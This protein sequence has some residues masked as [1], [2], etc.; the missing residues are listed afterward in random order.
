MCCLVR[1]AL[2]AGSSRRSI[3]VPTRMMGVPE[4]WCVISG[5]HYLW[6]DILVLLT[7]GNRRCISYLGSNVVVGWRAHNGEA[8]EK[9]IS[10]RI[11][12]GSESII[13]LLTC[14][15]PKTQTDWLAINNDASRVV[16][17]PA[18]RISMSAEK[19]QTQLFFIHRKAVLT[20]SGCTLRGKHWSCTR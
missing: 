18:M 12:Q 16:V 8:D 14:S 4:E 19:S 9:Y 13:I 11:G 7:D 10:L 15:I 6:S 1:V 5:S 17:K 20:R 3:L 2:V